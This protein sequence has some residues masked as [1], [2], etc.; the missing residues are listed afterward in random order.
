MNILLFKSKPQRA[1]C[2]E[3]LW[4]DCR[5]LFS[6]DPWTQAFQTAWG[7]EADVLE[8]LDNCNL[9]HGLPIV[10]RTFDEGAVAWQ[11]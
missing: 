1:I 7:S 8:T 2:I 4:G 3:H 10:H 9:R 5:A 11:P 6:G